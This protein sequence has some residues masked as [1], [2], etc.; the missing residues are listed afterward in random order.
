M[1]AHLNFNPFLCPSYSAST[2][3][4]EVDLGSPVPNPA[5]PAALTLPHTEA[6]MVLVNARLATFWRDY[7]IRGSVPSTP[8]R[9]CS[10]PTP[11]DSAPRY[12]SK[13]ETS[14]PRLIPSYEYTPAPVTMTR[15]SSSPP[16]PSPSPSSL[17]S[18]F[19]QTSK[20]RLKCK[21]R[22][23][24]KDLLSALSPT[25]ST[26]AQ[27]HAHLTP[28]L[29]RTHAPQLSPP[30]QM[31][32]APPALRVDIGVPPAYD[33][34]LGGELERRRGHRQEAGANRR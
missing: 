10:K 18:P 14:S 34:E 29:L 30:Q 32:P 23:P 21:R 27:A 12:H 24:V 31:P 16:A 22:S 13:F 33:E 9:C 2:F 4:S 5:K 19:S 15:S 11:Y 20:S 28:C 25:S 1:R 17:S 3:N 26:A 8:E 6:F 7:T